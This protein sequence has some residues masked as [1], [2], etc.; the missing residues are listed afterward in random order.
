MMLSAHQPAY[1]PWLGYL[2]K[3]ARSDLFMYL[4]EVQFEKNSFI[5]RNR[6]KTPQGAQWLT[7]PVKMKGHI[8]ATLRYTAMDDSQPWRRK[9]LAAVSLNYRKALF[10]DYAYPKLETLLG[11]AT[12]NLADFCWQHL[13][14]WIAE[15]EIGTRIVR[16]TQAPVEGSKSELVLNLCL[17]HNAD[18]YLSGELGRDYLDVASFKQRGIDVRFQKFQPQP[19]TQLW[20]A[21]EPGLSVLDYWMNCG[22]GQ[23]PAG[24]GADGVQ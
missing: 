8:D 21:F 12:Q 20:G 16:Q 22:P 7:V 17:R 13:Q 18:A 15:F 24:G 10:F 4:D 5:N 9:H 3:I 6:I 1:L 19:Y 2:D 23:L 11:A 14:F